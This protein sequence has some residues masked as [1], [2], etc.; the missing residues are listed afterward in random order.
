MNTVQLV[1][2]T[3]TGLAAIA[4]IVALVY[5]RFPLHKI[6]KS[7]VGYESMLD[8]IGDPL[9]VIAPDYTVRRANRAYIDLVSGSFRTAIGKKCYS[10]LKGLNEPCADCRIPI[11]ESLCRPE[12][13]ERSQHP[14]GAG[15][16]R[17]SFSPFFQAEDPEKNLVIEHI[18]DI[19]QLEAL[20]TDLEE[21]NRTLADAM[22]DL[23]A[24]QREI[25]DELR[26]A[27]QV[28][29]GIM[30]KTAPP[31]PGLSIHITFHSVE[32]VGGDLYDFIPFSADELGVFV[33]DASG[34]GFSAAL[35][36]M[37]AK[38]SLYNNSK[39][40]D[41]PGGLIAA[42]NR[43][44]FAIVQ[45]NHYL[46]CILGV[47][48]RVEHTFTFCRAGHPMPVVVRRDGSL[49]SLEGS[50]PM[51]GIIEDATFDESVFAWEPGDRFYLFTDGMYE[52]RKGEERSF[53]Y[54]RFTELLQGY[55]DVPAE[56][57]AEKLEERFRGFTCDDDYTM[58][59]IEAGLPS[60][61]E[62]LS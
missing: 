41:S 24:A 3:L 19:S 53:G 30:P 13:V 59:V 27:R 7:K 4:A 1:S 21:K 10:L 44:L 16:V 20:K 32:E 33:G 34:H 62:Q 56:S 58:L 35:I 17:L 57:V 11:V 45:T 36:G 40:G 26:L 23:K 55:N 18:R 28:Q 46:T 22:R 43:D 39:L 14:S 52:R 38:M 29:E 15:A 5:R 50:G 9:A 6:Y 61:T 51:A 47:F 2:G 48:N 60:P 54:D 42:I 31:F 49:F 12:V 25:K 37:I 8:A